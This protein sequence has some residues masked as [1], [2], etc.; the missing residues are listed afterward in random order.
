MIRAWG[1]ARLW[2]WVQAHPMRVDA[3]LSLALAAPAIVP[4][5]IRL[6]RGYDTP[7]HIL[8]FA[9]LDQAISAGQVLPRWSPDLMSGYGYPLFNF[10]APA[11]YY[12]GLLFRRLGADWTVV[13]QGVAAL[14]LGAAAVGAWRFCRDLVDADGEPA[15]SGQRVAAV[16][17]AGLYLYAPYLLINVYARGAIAEVAAQALLPWAL[18]LLRRVI[19]QR[20]PLTSVL[21]ATLALSGIVFS[22][23]IS[24]LLIPPFVAV[25]A[26]AQLHARPGRWLW[27]G[28]VGGLTIGLT[29]VFWLPLFIERSAVGTTAYLAALPSEAETFLHFGNWV[30]AGVPYPYERITSGL[31]FGLSPLHLALGGLSFTVLW[32]RLNYERVVLGLTALVVA[33][34]QLDATRPLWAIGGLLEIVQAPSRLQT[35][36]YLSIAG[37]TAIAAANL[38]RQAIRWPL[39][40][41]LIGAAIGVGAPWATH[42]PLWL[43]DT[44]D[45]GAA[46]I[47]HAETI[48]PMPGLSI[49]PDFLPRWVDYPVALAKP[50]PTAST[51]ASARLTAFGPGEFQVVVQSRTAWELRT[52]DFYFPGWAAW[53]DGAPVDVEPSTSL[54][55]VTIAVPAGTHD[56]HVA[57]VGSDVQHIAAW[58]SALTGAALTC[59]LLWRRRHVAAVI[60]G[61]VTG[62]LLW[63][64]P[65]HSLQPRAVASRP[66]PVDG[67]P[68][69]LL[70]VQAAQTGAGRVEIDAVWFVR[71]TA[72]DVSLRWALR[73]ATGQVVAS[74]QARPWFDQVH[75]QAWPAG[76]LADDRAE[77]VLAGGI[78]AGTYALT[79]CAQPDAERATP[80]DPVSVVQDVVAITRSTPAADARAAQDRFEGG[81]ELVDAILETRQGDRDLASTVPVVSPQDV[82]VLRL[83]W[84]V[85]D[86]LA[87]ERLDSSPIVMTQ[88]NGRLSYSTMPLTGLQG[89]L[90]AVQPGGIIVDR[91]QISL[92]PSAN[93]GR[94][95]VTVRVFNPDTASYLRALDGD[96]PV[97]DVVTV[98]QIRVVVATSAQ[99]D[100]THP[101]A[102]GDVARFIGYNLPVNDR[103]V[104]PGDTVTLTVVYQALRPADR[105][106]TQFTHLYDTTL[107]LI[108]QIDSPPLGGNNP[109]PGWISGEV[110]RD[111]L[112]MKV[113]SEATSGDYA[114]L[115]GLY[116]PA[117]GERVLVTLPDGT[118]PPD[119]ALLLETLHVVAP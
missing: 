39:G 114:L 67:A 36:L 20:D 88:Q 35:L 74:A 110:I 86:W 66:S 87:P 22:H 9:L 44:G 53:I 104:H 58:L 115:W 48:G 93:G 41:A 62:S 16:I 52:A 59:L 21:P 101:A 98:G 100:H 118:Q 33:V 8:R 82:L 73:D 49:Y 4:L 51:D 37:L 75:S 15:N 28:V 78:A 31:S 80:C 24:L 10:Y 47:A 79:V 42:A 17:G 11:V 113:S 65:I 89:W 103:T 94:Y 6:T 97:T 3:A 18:W 43:E 68:F 107:G 23:T 105:E 46:Q 111:V 55:L 5:I 57:Y 95:P 2:R 85:R 29:A 45:T 71:R 117:T 84:R 60:A 109:A 12:L 70:D 108:G 38:Q 40:V 64:S 32:K 96:V 56:L 34:L 81:L 99:V 7:P 77:I 25:L 116:D 1:N 50:A 19:R 76:T 92:D 112:T 63:I 102:L 119:R 26:M 91:Q 61:V 72:P 30:W 90:R 13:F 54:G 83:R 69:D 106:L 14:L 27:V